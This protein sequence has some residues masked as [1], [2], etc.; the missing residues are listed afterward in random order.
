[1]IIGTKKNLSYNA[2]GLTYT[3]YKAHLFVKVFKQIFCKL[4]EKLIQAGC[5]NMSRF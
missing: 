4:N 1:M 3:A 5:F 2:F